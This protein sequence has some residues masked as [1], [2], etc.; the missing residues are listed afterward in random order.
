M[1]VNTVV[2][3]PTKECPF[4][5]Y[6]NFVHDVGQ[7]GTCETPSSYQTCWA[8]QEILLSASIVTSCNQSGEGNKC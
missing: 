3:K 8:Y 1:M 6:C 7:N 2:F 4:L 5:N